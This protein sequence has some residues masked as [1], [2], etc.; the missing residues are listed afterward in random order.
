MAQHRTYRHARLLAGT[1]P[2]QGCWLRPCRARLWPHIHG[3]WSVF[4]MELYDSHIAVV[5]N[6]D[7]CLCVYSKLCRRQ[8]QATK[9]YRALA[10]PTEHWQ[11]VQSKLLHPV[12]HCTASSTITVMHDY[13]RI[14]SFP[15]P[16]RCS[17]PHKSHLWWL[18]VT[19]GLWWI[20][21]KLICCHLCSQSSL[22]HHDNLT[23]KQ[24]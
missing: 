9:A 8:G 14:S 24:V 13:L 5:C 17:V 19:S 7:V 3:C 2:W 10:M 12:T 11:L 6:R 16:P 20:C 4:M 22:T 15:L 23:F 18:C 21:L 1:T